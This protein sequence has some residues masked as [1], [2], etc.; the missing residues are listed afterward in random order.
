MLYP[1]YTG[2]PISDSN[3]K[4]LTTVTG[5]GFLS[6]NNIVVNNALKQAFILTNSTNMLRF[7]TFHTFLVANF[8]ASEKSSFYNHS[9]TKWDGAI[10]GMGT[11]TNMHDYNKDQIYN[12]TDWDYSGKG[13]I[14]R[15]STSTSENCD[16]NV[17]CFNTP[18]N[19]GLYITSSGT[20]ATGAS[21]RCAILSDHQQGF[22]WQIVNTT[23]TVPPIP[24]SRKA[25]DV[26]AFK[27]EAVRIEMMGGLEVIQR[28]AE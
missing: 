14:G 6:T 27:E 10:N 22:K 9:N 11:Y 25:F 21:T 18:L 8:T 16:A 1:N 15:A 7:R 17:S 23:N 12:T 2:T 13:D 24:S 4:T 19:I 3:I 28:M 5:S 26:Q 20:N